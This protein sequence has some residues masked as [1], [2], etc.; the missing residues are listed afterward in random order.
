MVTSAL[1]QDRVS[2]LK[3]KPSRQIM[4]FPPRSPPCD[5]AAVAHRDVLSEG[6][7]EI[8]PTIIFHRNGNITVHL[9]NDDRLLAHLSPWQERLVTASKDTPGSGARRLWVLQAHLPRRGGS[10][11]RGAVERTRSRHAWSGRSYPGWYTNPRGPDVSAK[12]VQFFGQQH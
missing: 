8:L 5:R 7:Q 2:T 9:R 12:M 6:Y 4:I 1:L 3:Y 11:S 10:R